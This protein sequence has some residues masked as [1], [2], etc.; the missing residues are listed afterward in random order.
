[1]NQ[2]PMKT[3]DFTDTELETLRA[4]IYKEMMACC[5]C[6]DQTYQSDLQLMFDKLK[7]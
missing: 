1:M 7:S 6:K 2:T 3:L 5:R 4:L